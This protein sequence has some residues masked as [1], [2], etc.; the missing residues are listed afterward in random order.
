M[1]I[2]FHSLQESSSDSKLS[3]GSAS[4]KQSIRDPRLKKPE[5]VTDNKTDTS[6]NNV[7]AETL[8][9]EPSAVKT[10]TIV[11]NA[12]KT[13][14][15]VD[16][17]VKTASIVDNAVKTATI[18]DKAV[19]TATIVDKAVKTATIVDNAVKTASIVDNAVKTASIVDKPV[20][21]VGFDL[22]FVP[23]DKD[24]DTVKTTPSLTYNRDRPLGKNRYFRKDPK[25]KITKSDS[26]SGSDFADSKV[27]RSDS[28][29]AKKRLRGIGHRNYRQRLEP[30]K[31]NDRHETLDERKRSD[32]GRGRRRHSGDRPGNHSNDRSGEPTT[33]H[34]RPD[35]RDHHRPGEHSDDRLGKRRGDFPDAPDR[36]GV[37]PGGNRLGERPD[38]IGRRGDRPGEHP[39]RPGPRDLGDRPGRRPDDRPGDLHGERPRG[40]LSKRPG[41][42]VDIGHRHPLRR[43]HDEYESIHGSRL[44]RRE[45]WTRGRGQRRY[46]TNLRTYTAF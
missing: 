23:L 30:T 10:A 14:T 25:A 43:E 1:L 4:V 36:P 18:V 9:E 8:E 32:R 35:G 37:R 45:E 28:H 2:V 27:S 34:D 24:D 38:E 39:N 17:A 40:R 5:Q 19:K 33:G 31:E 12:V 3:E 46:C 42:L 6:T 11:D 41:D 13:A 29:E 16:N 26:D 44:D 7:E 20:D 15:I 21:K 22:E